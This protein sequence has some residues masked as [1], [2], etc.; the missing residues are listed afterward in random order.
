MS[1]QYAATFPVPPE[2]EQP[3]NRPLRSRRRDARAY[4][5]GLYPTHA[6]GTIAQ[7]SHTL[8]PTGFSGRIEL[9]DADAAKA[10]FDDARFEEDDTWVRMRI[11]VPFRELLI[12]TQH[13]HEYAEHP[14]PKLRPSGF[15]PILSV[16]HTLD[17]ALMC[18]W[19]TPPQGEGE[20]EG[21]TGSSTAPDRVLDE[22]KLTIPLSFVRVPRSGPNCP[23]AEE[24]ST[25]DG[26]S[27]VSHTGAAGSVQM[28]PE[29]IVPSQPYAQSLPAYNQLYHKNGM[30][31][32]DPTPLPLYT[33]Q[34]QSPEDVRVPTV[35]D[36]MICKQTPLPKAKTYSTP[37][38]PPLS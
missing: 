27:P 4:E 32:E 19:D 33:P 10:S 11:D 31:R 23:S 25:A 12:D 3:P 6:P 15:G 5:C 26:L 24:S 20:G 34:G 29:R 14:V 8:L 28:L 13:L 37:A 1:R 18:A 30:R 7:A 38:L 16:V 35:P 2:S 22:L 21:E 9:A 36:M 17:I